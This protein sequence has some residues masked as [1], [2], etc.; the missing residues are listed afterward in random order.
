MITVIRNSCFNS[1]ASCFLMKVRTAW[2]ASGSATVIMSMISPIPGKVIAFAMNSWKDTHTQVISETFFYRHETLTSTRKEVGTHLIQAWVGEY[3]FDP[4][5]KLRVKNQSL[6]LLEI[7]YQTE[8]QLPCQHLSRLPPKR[9]IILIFDYSNL[10]SAKMYWTR[11]L[12]N[13]H[14]LNSS[15]SWARRKRRSLSVRSDSSLMGAL[16]PR[17]I[18]GVGL[19]DTSLNTNSSSFCTVQEKSPLL[20]P[21]YVIGGT[22][23]RISIY[24]WSK[25]S[26]CSAYIELN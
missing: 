14:R 18:D 19:S 2:T 17:N 16:N 6:I 4:L 8:H 3:A 22:K 7:S 25:L 13:T 1:E 5:Q 24:I 15:E 10:W 23:C 11:D 12:K 9:Q 20:H 26:L 21:Y